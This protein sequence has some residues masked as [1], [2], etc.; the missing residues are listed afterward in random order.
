MDAGQNAMFATNSCLSSSYLGF[1]RFEDALRTIRTWIHPVFSRI[2]KFVLVKK[3]TTSLTFGGNDGASFEL[4]LKSLVLRKIESISSAILAH[5]NS[6]HDIQ[7]TFANNVFSDK[8]YGTAFHGFV[9]LCYHLK[10]ELLRR[11][12]SIYN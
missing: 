5:D 11:F 10:Q 9:L 3:F 4:N 8:C 2:L 7:C 1:Q 6:K 12:L